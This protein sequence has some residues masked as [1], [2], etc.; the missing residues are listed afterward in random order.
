VEC[1]VLV[2]KFLEV[3]EGCSIVKTSFV[4]DG[5]QNSGIALAIVA[6]FL[7]LSKSYNIK[8]PIVSTKS[9]T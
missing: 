4:M 1:E 6:I 3:G 9:S 7:L 8:I 5:I 2:E